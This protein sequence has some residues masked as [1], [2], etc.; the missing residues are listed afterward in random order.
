MNCTFCNIVNKKAP[1]WT[2][3]QDEYI[4]AFFDYYPASKWHVL[5]V[6]NNHYSD[7]FETPDDILWRIIALAKKISLFYKKELWINNINI[8]QSNGEVAWQ[9]VF[10]YHMHIVPRVKNDKVT[11]HWVPDERIREEYDE[12]KTFI[13]DWINN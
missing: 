1:S 4:S 2:I 8:V 11:L 9:E 13:S 7:I 3:Y 12:L 10:H 5:I 6:P